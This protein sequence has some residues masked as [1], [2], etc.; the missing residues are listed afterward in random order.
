MRIFF[1][2]LLIFI[3]GLLIALIL[4]QQKGSGAGSVFGGGGSDVYRTRR[5]IDKLLHY[6]TIILA[7][8]Y[9]AVSFSLIFIR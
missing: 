8:L 9:S 6:L 7:F 5:G 1:L 3:A 4:L 2:I